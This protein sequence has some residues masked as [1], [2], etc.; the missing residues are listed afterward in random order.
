MFLHVVDSETSSNYH[1]GHI[2]THENVHSSS[3]SLVKCKPLSVG[4]FENT[5]LHTV[6]W[7]LVLN[8]IK[9]YRLDKAHKNKKGHTRQSYYSR[10]SERK[11]PQWKKKSSA[12]MTRGTEH[13]GILNTSLGLMQP[14]TTSSRSR[15]LRNN[16]K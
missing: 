8:S 3:E 15:S 2:L 5:T 14:L 10:I 13:T 16:T 11:N 7:T 9:L 6:S 1:Q 4:M 12:D